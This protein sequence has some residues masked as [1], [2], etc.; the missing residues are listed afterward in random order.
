MAVN[1]LKM[2]K[3]ERACGYPVLGAKNDKS[4]LHAVEETRVPYAELVSE[5][6]RSWIDVGI[7][8]HSA[9]FGVAPA[10]R[11]H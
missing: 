2:A 1:R 5:D 11:A 3:I 4:A 10:R 8:A 6:R 9:A 7:V